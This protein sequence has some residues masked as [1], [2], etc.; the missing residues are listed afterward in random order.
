M[1]NSEFLLFSEYPSCFL[2]KTIT[3]CFKAIKFARGSKINDKSNHDN[4]AK[5][6]FT[7]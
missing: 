6:N 3:S 4:T 2:L 1:Q 5:A 7:A